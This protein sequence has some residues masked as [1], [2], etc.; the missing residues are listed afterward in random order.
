MK[1]IICLLIGI[2]AIS[3]HHS[4]YAQKQFSGWVASFNT[5]SLD[6]K[7]SIH[8]DAQI[9][10]SNDHHHI[11]SVLLRP[12]LTFN[13]RKNM[14]V[15]AGYAFIHNRRTI[16]NISG[17]APEHR[18]WEQFL[19]THK[20]GAATLN[21]RF[22]VEQRFISKS[23]IENNTLVNEGTVYANRF[24]YFARALLPLFADK[25]PFLALQ[26]EVFLNF[27]DKSSV[28]GKV[29]DQNRA[30]FAAG[31]RFDKTFDAELGYLNQYISGRDIAFTNNHVIQIATY[32]RL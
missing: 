9:R 2:C 22:R 30:Y 26:N 6:K 21:H 14:R 28:N 23:F 4:S 1:Y 20:I 18:I 5:F 15:T 19:I 27:G 25:G 29:F 31:Y 24:R 8:F 3:I 17:Y 11:Q 13:V 7:F 32:F 10:S 16:N 12:G